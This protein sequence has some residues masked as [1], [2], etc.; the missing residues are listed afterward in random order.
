MTYDELLAARR[1]AT[2]L[3][4]DIIYGRVQGNVKE[5]AKAMFRS[6]MMKPDPGPTKEQLEQEARHDADRLKLKRQRD[7]DSLYEQS[8][9]CPHPKSGLDLKCVKCGAPGYWDQTESSDG[10][11]AKSYW[12]SINQWPAN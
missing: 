1:K 9:Q 12:R 11:P 10:T 5:A 3:V 7:E 4:H 2:Q 8:N 6:D